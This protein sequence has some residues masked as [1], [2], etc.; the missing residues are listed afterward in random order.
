ME[1]QKSI[2]EVDQNTEGNF[3]VL[4]ETKKAIEEFKRLNE[5]KKALIDR[6]EK[7]LSH[8]LLAGRSSAGR[9]RKSQKE[10]DD[11]KEKALIDMYMRA[12]GR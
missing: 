5:E 3:S 7:L 10:L 6:E 1:N 4:E 9:V 11:E 8:E 12:V 2:E